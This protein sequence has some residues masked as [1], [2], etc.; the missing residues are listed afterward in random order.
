[1]EQ[2]H[3]YRMYQGRRHTKPI[4]ADMTIAA[5]AHCNQGK[6]PHYKTSR[7]IT[8]IQT[9]RFPRYIDVEIYSSFLFYF[10]L[11]LSAERGY[12]ERCFIVQQIYIYK[13]LLL[14]PSALQPSLF[15]L[16]EKEN[17]IFFAKL[18]IPQTST[19][20]IS[21][22]RGVRNNRTDVTSTPIKI[23]ANPVLAPV[24][25]ITADLE[26]D[27][28]IRI[29]GVRLATLRQRGKGVHLASAQVMQVAEGVKWN[30]GYAAK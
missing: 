12:V 22:K 11:F 17:I 30:R 24:S 13:H 27:P 15:W 14:A 29:R 16:H 3:D 23:P 9:T 5:S 21:A 8:N 28:A 1:M 20:G 6:H 26:K 18:D 25:C 19:C 2:F 10:E 4:T 7:S